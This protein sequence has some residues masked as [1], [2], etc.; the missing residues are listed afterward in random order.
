[1]KF[2]ADFAHKGAIYLMVEETVNLEDVS[3]VNFAL[4]QNLLLQEF[5][6]FHHQIENTIL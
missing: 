4:I 1:M 5:H 6:K 3:L 2:F